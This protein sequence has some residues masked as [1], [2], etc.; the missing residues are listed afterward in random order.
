MS[1][2]RIPAIG[3][4]AI[5][6]A[7]WLDQEISATELR[8]AELEREVEWRTEQVQ[9]LAAE[10][11]RQKLEAE[12]AT[13]SRLQA[14]RDRLEAERAAARDRLRSTRAAARLARQAYESWLVKEYLAAAALMIAGRQLEMTWMQLNSAFENAADAIFG[15]RDPDQRAAKSRSLFGDDAGSDEIT[16][17]PVSLVLAVGR[18]PQLLLQTLTLPAVVTLHQLLD[19]TPPDQV[20]VPICEPIA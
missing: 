11:A 3:P 16:E 19:S 20:P 8:I 17:P 10:G 6:D 18:K 2:A 1:D 4:A 12:R 5:F 9:T 14:D 13:L 7:A 15:T